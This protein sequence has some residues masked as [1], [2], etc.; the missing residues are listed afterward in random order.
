MSNKK[1]NHYKCSQQEL[2][3]VCKLAWEGCNMH[4]AKFQNFSPKYNPEFIKAR[5]EEIAA[6]VAI[7][8]SASRASY[9]EATRL[10]LKEQA[11]NCLNLWKRLRRHILESY[12]PVLQENKLKAAGKPYYR[13]AMANSWEACQGLMDTASQFLAAESEPLL[14]N[15]NMPPGFPDEFNAARDAFESLY[16]NFLEGAKLAAQKTDEKI[17]ANNSIFDTMMAMMLNGQ[18][19]FWQ[20]PVIQ[21]QFVFDHLLLTVSGIGV[22][23]FKGKVTTGTKN[24]TPIEGAL[25]TLPD[26]NHT[27]TTDDEGWYQFTQLQAG[28]YSLEVTAPGF[29]PLKIDNI[30]I[31]TGNMS[32]LHLQ[33]VAEG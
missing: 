15:D 14:R 24:S 33:M 20:D 27:C 31:K 12:S 19:I 3:A 17:T 26:T 7:P 21:K 22:A 32:N 4:L 8:G 30:E 13:D 5:K 18:E 6:V 11:R 25:L 2:Y 29:V 23:G 10:E 9:V 16:M 1:Q 28:R